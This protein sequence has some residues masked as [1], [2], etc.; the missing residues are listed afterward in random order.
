MEAN[1]SEIPRVHVDWISFTCQLYGIIN[2]IGHIWY[3]PFFRAAGIT[4]C[5]RVLQKLQSKFTKQNTFNSS[6]SEERDVWKKL[7]TTDH[8]S[9]GSEQKVKVTRQDLDILL[10]LNLLYL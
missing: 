9:G 8:D 7:S 1:F 2:L 3:S 5:V 4:E 10:R 6:N